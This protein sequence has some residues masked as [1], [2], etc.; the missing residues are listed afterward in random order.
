VV[1]TDFNNVEGNIPN[2]TGNQSS[3]HTNIANCRNEAS[4]NVPQKMDT[5]VQFPKNV[6]SPQA[7][8]LLVLH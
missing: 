8:S 2:Y 7:R 5:T 3:K 1:P 4:I 6:N